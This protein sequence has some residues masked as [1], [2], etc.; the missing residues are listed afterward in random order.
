M[1]MLAYKTQNKVN[2]ICDRLERR[3]ETVCAA[4]IL[5]YLPEVNSVSA[6][7]IYL[8]NWQVSR[9]ASTQRFYDHLGGNSAFT[10]LFLSEMSRFSVHK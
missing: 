10:H 1:D 2:Q 3:D 8:N 4:N 6:A 9:E 5:K 7:E